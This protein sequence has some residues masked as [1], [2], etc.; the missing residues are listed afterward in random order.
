MFCPKCG[1]ADQNANSYCRNC[2]EFL[3]DFTKTG[4]QA[5]GGSTPQQ[6]INTTLF[7]SLL[8]AIVALLS[9]IALYATHLGRNDVLWSV[10]LAAAFLLTIAAWQTSNFFVAL[11]LRK[12]FKNRQNLMR[13]DDLNQ[14]VNQ[15][16]TNFAALPEANESQFIKP[17][18][19][20]ENTTE[21]LEP[22]PLKR[23]D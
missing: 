13:N 23:R 18:T 1:K 12:H 5:F 16:D 4:K 14:P 17:Q 15:L 20:V 9:A 8:T 21:L 11:K 3:Q 10:Y 2:G 6:N 7:F 19:V 22:V